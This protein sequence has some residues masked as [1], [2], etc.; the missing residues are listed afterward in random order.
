MSEPIFVYCF[1]ALSLGALGESFSDDIFELALEPQV[2]S[3]QQG[4]HGSS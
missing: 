4:H 2:K 1:D 3:S